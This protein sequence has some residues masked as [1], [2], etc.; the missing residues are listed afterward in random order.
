[1]Y[2]SIAEFTG[3]WKKESQST[4][5]LLK[6]LTDASLSQKVYAEGRTLGF[7]AWHLVS[8][9]A[10]MGSKVGFNFGEID[11][12]TPMPQNASDIASTY[13]KL[14]TSLAEQVGAWGDE[15]L[16]EEDDMYGEKWSKNMTLHVL[17]RHEI[18]H[19]AQMTVL[20]RQAG[21]P[22]PGVYGPSK[23]EWAA[24]GMPPME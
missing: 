3:D 10:E 2:E 7:I 15:R 21:L 1:M 11:E 17:I 20:M 9:I 12:K 22:V 14:A 16:A 8:S 18:H 24:Y 5:K 19:R 13:E 6:N 4:I 23:E